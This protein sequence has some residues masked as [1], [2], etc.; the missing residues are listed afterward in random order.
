VQP[1]TLRTTRKTRRRRRRTRSCLFPA[2]PSS[3]SCVCVCPPTAFMLIP[4]S[5]SSSPRNE[6]VLNGF[7]ASKRC[8]TTVL[9]DSLLCDKI[10]LKPLE[11]LELC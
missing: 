2:A 3:P 8:P 1:P 5:L 6:T 11:I 7:V 4:S 10:S 9:E